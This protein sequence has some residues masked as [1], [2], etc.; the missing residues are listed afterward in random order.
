MHCRPFWPYCKQEVRL[1]LMEKHRSKVIHMAV[2]VG[3]AIT[4]TIVG[5]GHLAKWSWGAFVVRTGTLL[6]D[7]FGDRS[8]SKILMKGGE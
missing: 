2:F 1:D 3:I 5:E 8:L 6:A 4:L 7:I